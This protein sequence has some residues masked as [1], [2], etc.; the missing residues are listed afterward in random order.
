[1][2]QHDIDFQLNELKLYRDKNKQ[3]EATIKEMKRTI[4]R[5]QKKLG[6]A[7]TKSSWNQGGSGFMNQLK[8]S[9]KGYSSSDEDDV[10]FLFSLYKTG[11]RGRGESARA[12]GAPR[13]AGG[14]AQTGPERDVQGLAGQRVQEEGEASE[15]RE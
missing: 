11:H 3:H 12:P 6:V 5:L 4:D 2:A 13:E 9:L 1:M 15:N 14:A 10:L 8:Q 7:P